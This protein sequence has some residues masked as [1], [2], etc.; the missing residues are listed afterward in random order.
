MITLNYMRWSNFF[1]YGQD[2]YLRLDDEV[3]KQLIASNGAGKTSILLI[4]EE[5]LYGK[6]HKG[7]KKVDLLNRNSKAKTLN[8]EVGFTKGEDSFV[9]TLSRSPGLKVFLTRNMVDISRHTGAQT[10]KLVEE[11]LGINYVL[12]NQLTYLSTDSKLRFLTDTDTERKKFLVRLFQ[13]DIYLEKHE[14]LKS[15]TKNIDGDLKFIVGATNTLD[16]LI[17]NDSNISN[18]ELGMQKVVPEVIKTDKNIL[19]SDLVNIRRINATREKNN[20]YK[21]ML[22]V[23]DKSALVDRLYPPIASALKEQQEKK[24]SINNRISNN[25]DRISKINKLGDKCPTCFNTIDKEGVTNLKLQSSN[26]IEGL[27]LELSEVKRAINEISKETLAY[28]NYLKV[29]DEFERLTNLIDEEIEAELLD[30]SE[31]ERELAKIKSEI[32]CNREDISKIEAYNVKVTESNYRINAAVANVHKYQKELELRQKEFDTLKSSLGI[33]T[34][35]KDIFSTKGL[36]AYKLQ[37]LVL[38]LEKQINAYLSELS[39]GKF[40]LN[41]SLEGDKLNVIIIDNGKEI[42]ISALSTGELSLVEISTL[43]AVRKLMCSISGTSLNLLFLDE[44]ISVLSEQNKEIVLE[45]LAKEQGLN[46][47]VVS[48]GFSLPTLPALEIIKVDGISKIK[49]Y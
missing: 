39:K 24:G 26:R 32:A 45:L 27:E 33:A 6:N 13:L 10:L 22:S 14:K 48:H 43:L 38:D 19:D 30:K 25:R 28:S 16:M 1:S 40:L 31:L 49:E 5:L 46:I 42:D 36:L 17:R 2:N 37:F 8:G 41:F 21:A 3:V 35:L 11:I 7:V 23:L 29:S 34:T 18:K 47:L 9:V 15:T 44:V 12:F 4:L 20:S